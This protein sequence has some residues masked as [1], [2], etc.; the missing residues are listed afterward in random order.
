MKTELNQNQY[1]CNARRLFIFKRLLAE[2]LNAD[3]YQEMLT[4]QS[5]EDRQL[6]VELEERSWIPAVQ[7][8]AI[9][10]NICRTIGHTNLMYT[11]GQEGIAELLPYVL[12]HN[13]MMR[14]IREV[15]EA[16]P[17]L[18]S[19]W[20]NPVVCRVYPEADCLLVEVQGLHDPVLE[21]LF[22]EGA[23]HGLFNFMRLKQAATVMLSLPHNEA[24]ELPT[25]FANLPHL[26][27]ADTVVR[28]GLGLA[29]Q[30][31]QQK[32]LES[33]L[34]RD[35]VS[36]STHKKNQRELFVRQVLSRSSRLFQDKRELTT[37]VEYLNIANE[38]LERKINESARELDM[39]RN[40]QN[41]LIPGTIPDW[42]G[43]RFWNYSRPLAGVSGDLYDYFNISEGCLGLMVA[44]VC[45]HGVP[46][47]L[48][49]A[50]AKISFT[51]HS[52]INPRDVL[53]NVNLDII[54]HVRMEGY[55]TASYLVIDRDHKIQYCMG[56]LPAPMIFHA[57]TGTVSK[58]HSTGTLLGM[59]PNAS[60][61]LTNN[62]I[63]LKS[64]DK[65][66]IYTDGVTETF[67]TQDEILGT[68]RLVEYF[69]E[70]GGMDAEQTGQH[71]LKR[72]RQFA[73]GTPPSDDLT[74]VVVEI[75]PHYDYFKRYRANARRYYRENKLYEA[76]EEL[77]NAVH[78]FPQKPG[79]LYSLAK[80]LV[81][82][83]RFDEAR[84][85]IDQLLH[86]NPHHSGAAVIEALC[87]MHQGRLG[88][89][90][91]Q[92]KRALALK[93][94]NPPALYHLIR[95]QIQLG[96]KEE[97]QS[98]LALLIQITPDDTNLQQLRNLLDA[99]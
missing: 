53:S 5:K 34:V 80:I 57:R 32:P 61:H 20:I 97:A 40:I 65:L 12:P 41:G 52:G 1:E 18:I 76:S 85:Y 22:L 30:S 46:A 24:T 86:L 89:A 62:E 67:N 63:Q 73:L 55:L 59:F 68:D 45:G 91:N 66:L 2:E 92:L 7:E 70:T 99:S 13:P 31:L 93:S 39:A 81:S 51:N 49:S 82:M 23:I 64:G 14:T 74:I 78:L 38:E 29:S 6:L 28:I 26:T 56:G 35:P 96:H 44:D 60:E 94:N 16:L 42:E 71:I 33:S 87:T 4:T 9:I 88:L 10:R 43:L 84:A 90:E 15:L 75:S 36:L 47:A 25:M 72:Q 8:L 21:A 77:R 54:S 69:Q 37:A 50:I 79:T 95:V 19:F 11:C 48:I 98:N 58:F 27:P 83:R 17:A 3:A